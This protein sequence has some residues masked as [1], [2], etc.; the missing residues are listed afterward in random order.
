MQHDI[1]DASS[2]LFG[3]NSLFIEELYDRYLKD[4]NSV[5]VSWQQFFDGVGD[6]QGRLAASWGANDEKIIGAKDPEA[7]A[8]TAKPGKDGA[9]GAAPGWRSTPRN[10]PPSSAMAPATATAY[11]CATA[12]AA[13]ASRRPS[14]WAN[15]R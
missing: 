3:G 12:A 9:K 2:Y 5:D 11:S 8:A 15:S 4:R 10:I 13:P 6:S 7:A 14:R 1:F